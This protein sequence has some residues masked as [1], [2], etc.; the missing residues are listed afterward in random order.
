MS[1]FARYSHTQGVMAA[2]TVKDPP[3]KS[4]LRAPDSLGTLN[5]P[6]LHLSAHIVDFAKNYQ[7][8]KIGNK[9]GQAG[10]QHL[11][12]QMKDV[13][14]RFRL[15]SLTQHECLD[16]HFVQ[17]F[18]ANTF[19]SRVETR[20]SA[21]NVMSGLYE[22]GIFT[23]KEKG[24]GAE[25]SRA[26]KKE[27]SR[28]EFKRGA[29][30]EPS[31]DEVSLRLEFENAAQ[32]VVFQHYMEQVYETLA[33]VTSGI[34]LTFVDTKFRTAAC[35]QGVIHHLQSTGAHLSPYK[36]I[37]FLQG[38]QITQMYVPAVQAIKNLQRLSL[39]HGFV[40]LF[41]YWKLHAQPVVEDPSSRHTLYNMAIWLLWAV[42]EQW[43]LE[44]GTMTERDHFLKS[45]HELALDE[46]TTFDIL[47][48]S[49]LQMDIVRRQNQMLLPSKSLNGTAAEQALLTTSSDGRTGQPRSRSRPTHPQRPQRPQPAHDVTTKP[50]PSAPERTPTRPKPICKDYLN[51]GCKY[52]AKE[53]S[54]RHPPPCHDFY[55]EGCRR[56]KCGFSHELTREG[57][58]ALKKSQADS[59]SQEA[60]HNEA[61]HKRNSGSSPSRSSAP[62][63]SSTPSR[64]ATPAGGR[65]SVNFAGAALQVSAPAPPSS[66]Q[67]LPDMDYASL[68]DHHMRR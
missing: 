4:F 3:G 57:Y 41:S 37:K 59:K 60:G 35:P 67:I 53:C 2:A 58:A 49:F 10:L 64:P 65:R 6:S 50:A 15:W 38:L 55:G 7:G 12:A 24:L 18:L 19:N 42:E 62:S 40:A 68:I 25:A 63:R 14:L 34:I 28:A 54:G 32:A 11:L 48:H 9:S 23:I 26:V 30:D 29:E 20:T 47:E 43:T 51:N 31:L 8:N 46:N 52:A 36:L 1:L 22:K 39:M 45:L 44:L 16:E 33:T 61:E 13:L 5:V 27:A 17:D 56:R 66:L 21:A